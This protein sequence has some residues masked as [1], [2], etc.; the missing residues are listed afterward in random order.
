M[1]FILAELIAIC[2]F[3]S[4]IYAAFHIFAFRIEW[5]AEQHDEN[6][7]ITRSRRRALSFLSSDVSKACKTHRRQAIYGFFAF[8]VIV[9][10]GL[11]MSL[12]FSL[13]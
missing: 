5:E 6:E 10:F 4:L 12:T 13:S 3:A 2:G 11:I 1:P 8:A 9:L 7:F